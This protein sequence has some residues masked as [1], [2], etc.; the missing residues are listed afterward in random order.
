MLIV[1]CFEVVSVCAILLLGR[2]FHAIFHGA[3]CQT[4]SSQR[5]FLVVWMPGLLPRGSPRI[6]KQRAPLGERFT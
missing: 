1:E 6:P 5:W 4:T 3:F 2:R